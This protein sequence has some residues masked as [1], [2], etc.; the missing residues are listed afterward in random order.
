M[1]SP[2]WGSQRR[3][4]HLRATRSPMLMASGR[5]SQLAFLSLF[6]AIASASKPPPTRNL[7]AVIT[8][9]S[10]GIGNSMA[11][12]AAAR[13]FDVVL[14]AR[15]VE[16]LKS[17]AASL[18]AAYGVNS[19]SVAVN[20]ADK[21]G[22]AKLHKAATKLCDVSLLI[23]NA[24]AA[25]VGD[26]ISQPINNIEQLVSL[27]MLSTTTLCRL[28]GADFAKRGRGAILI[29]SSLTALAPLP[30]AAL[31]GATKAFGHSLAGGLA[32]ELSPRGVIVKCLLPGA[33][34]T[35]FSKAAS[36][37]TSLAFT[38]PFFKPLGVLVSA[39]MAA[40]TALDALL[41]PIAAYT[42]V[43]AT[44]SFIQRSYATAARFLLPRALCGDFAE[45]FFGPQSPLRS[46]P[47]LLFALPILL[48]SAILVLFAVPMTA[49][50]DILFTPYL[51]VLFVLLPLVA[52][53]LARS[54]RLGRGA[55][56]RANHYA[57]VANVLFIAVRSC[58]A[59]CSRGIVELSCVRSPSATSPSGSSPPSSP[60]RMDEAA[61]ARRLH[62]A[63][64]GDEMRF[65]DGR[66]RRALG[67]GRESTNLRMSRRELR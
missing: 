18:R 44:P 33:T 32:S 4:E 7:C 37:E 8:G 35:E 49:V 59:I 42:S 63:L 52:L 3:G 64:E 55:L 9:A 14:A 60:S 46:P 13:G 43:D 53:L 21:S 31:Y 27:N 5:P 11:R 41:S 20:L 10:A 28:F 48:P 12:A 25:W 17:L 39:D 30:G 56:R 36:T 22:A 58:V 66:A 45:L 26:A 16:R 54:G 62:S 29:T 51:F 23:A 50:Q 67:L 15:R 65:Y 6:V 1:V 34:D 38:G 57:R 24:G 47:A 19:F 61:F 2:S 40:N